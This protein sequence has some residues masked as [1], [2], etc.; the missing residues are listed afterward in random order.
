MPFPP[1]A[2]SKLGSALRLLR[3]EVA[4]TQAAA[5]ERVGITRSCISH[6]ENDR[7]RPDLPTLDRLLTCY[8]VDLEGLQRALDEAP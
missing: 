7:H 5:A 4:L 3:K 2:F 6:Y 1:G 8:G